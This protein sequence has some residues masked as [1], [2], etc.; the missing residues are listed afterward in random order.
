MWS[1]ASARPKVVCRTAVSKDVQAKG[2]PA[3]QAF[4]LLDPVL[5]S[6]LRGRLVVEFPPA[7]LLLPV[8]EQTRRDVVPAA[9]LDRTAFP[10]EQLLHYLH[11]NSWLKVR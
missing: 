10:G 2:E 3:H 5:K 1:R 7:V 8:V 11:L 4:Q 6:R 9:E